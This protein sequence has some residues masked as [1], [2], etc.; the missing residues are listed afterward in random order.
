MVYR[1][2][3]IIMQTQV[4]ITKRAMITRTFRWLGFRLLTFAKVFVLDAIQ[5]E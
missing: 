5:I 4:G 1:A 3:S 2:I